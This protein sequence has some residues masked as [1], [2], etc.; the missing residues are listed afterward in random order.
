MEKIL[1]FLC[2]E[3][4]TLVVNLVRRYANENFSH[5]SSSPSQHSTN[6]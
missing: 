4:Y 2:I 3:C 1:D 6:C 5:G